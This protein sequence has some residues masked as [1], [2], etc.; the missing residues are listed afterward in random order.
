MGAPTELLVTLASSG[1]AA[2]L[3]RSL[4]VWLTQRHR[5]IAITIMAA[6]G[7]ALT[8]DAKRVQPGEIEHLVKS[9]L[10]L[11]EDIRQVAVPATASDSAQTDPPACPSEP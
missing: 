3:A 9:A 10:D 5:D 11:R 4:Q 7:R 1:T 8:I 6:D 2:V